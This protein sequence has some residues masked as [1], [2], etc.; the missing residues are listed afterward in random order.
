MVEPAVGKFQPNWEGPYVIV[1]VGASES[2]ALNKLDRM[3]VPKV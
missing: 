1:R 2:Y 3:P